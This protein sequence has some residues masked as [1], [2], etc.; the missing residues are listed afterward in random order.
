MKTKEELNALKTEVEN[1]SRK[2]SELSEEELNEV[3][4]GAHEITPA[5]RISDD[6]IIERL[7]YGN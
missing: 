1:L 2:L 6:E 7:I 3:T 5:K 4:G